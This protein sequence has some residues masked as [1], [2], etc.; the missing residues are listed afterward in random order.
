[1]AG[2]NLQLVAPHR[3]YRAA[4]DLS[5]PELRDA[6]DQGRADRRADLSNEALKSRLDLLKARGPEVRRAYLFGCGPD[7]VAAPGPLA[8][9]L[10]ALVASVWLSAVFEQRTGVRR[11]LASVI[12]LALLTIVSDWGFVRLGRRRAAELGLTVE[13]APERYLSGSTLMQLAFSIVQ[14]LRHR[15]RRGSWRGGG[16][17]PTS[18]AAAL[19]VRELMSRRSWRHTAGS[20]PP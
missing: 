5:R 1:M 3:F 13:T 12:A 9:V 10:P 18:S 8:L 17:T 20:D 16:P 15:I 14:V 11:R 19:V 7:H 4:P 2:V 6:Y